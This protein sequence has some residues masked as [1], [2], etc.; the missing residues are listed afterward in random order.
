MTTN[1]QND[2]DNSGETN[3]LGQPY[4]PQYEQGREQGADRGAAAGGQPH[5]FTLAVELLSLKATNVIRTVY[6]VIGV[7]AVVMGAAVLFWPVKT[8]AVVAIALGVYFLFS[9]V[10][11]IVSAIVDL[12]LPAGWRVLDI[13]V[14]VILCVGGVI[15]LKNSVLSGQ[16]LV[17]MMTVVIGIG[18][19][20]EGVLALAESWRLPGSGWAML[21]AVISIL[22][23]IV[24][25]MSPVSATLWLII[26]VGVALV[27]IGVSSIVRA[28]VFGRSARV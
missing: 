17:V 11:H 14:G 7:L 24:V 15:M 28:F 26:F 18:W 23:G 3:R 5:P 25:L 12:G 20:V 13:L 8:L 19:I 21:Y 2:S 1:P 16:A 27:V 22:A 9:G 6:A 4:N 10:F